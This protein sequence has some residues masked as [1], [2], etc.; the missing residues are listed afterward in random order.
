LNEVFVDQDGRPFKDVRIRY[1]VILGKTSFL[2]CFFK[3]FIYPSSFGNIDDPFPDPPGLLKPPSS[4]TRPPDIY[5]LACRYGLDEELRI[6]SRYTLGINMF[7][8]PPMED[9][10]YI[11]GY[12]YHRLFNLHR[13]R[14]K[15]AQNSATNRSVTL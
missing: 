6:A 7:D 10:K 8:G 4:P 12:S 11:T 1:V 13:Q 2:Y 5:A 15:A 14:S 9:L 3:N